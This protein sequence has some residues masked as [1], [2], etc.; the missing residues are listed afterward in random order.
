MSRLTDSSSPSSFRFS[1]SP[2]GIGK[3]EMN[4]HDA[5]EEGEEVQKALLLENLRGFQGC[6]IYIISV[7]FLIKLVDRAGVFIAVL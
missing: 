2:L 4:D 6:V 3:P 7:A 5:L 1:F